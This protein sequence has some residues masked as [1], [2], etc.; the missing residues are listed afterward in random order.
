MITIKERRTKKRFESIFKIWSKVSNCW[1]IVVFFFSLFNKRI[2]RIYY[3][4]I[5]YSILLL[6]NNLFNCFLSFRLNHNL[7]SFFKNN[8]EK[9]KFSFFSIYVLRNF[10][11]VRCCWMKWFCGFSGCLFWWLGLIVVEVVLD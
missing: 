4:R 3:D 5:W 1:V 6:V 11:F 10:S 7:K 2:I 9:Q 8:W